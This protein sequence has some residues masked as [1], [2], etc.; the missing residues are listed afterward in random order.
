MSKKNSLRCIS[1]SSLIKKATSKAA[2]LALASLASHG[3]NDNHSPQSLPNLPALLSFFNQY[4]LLFWSLRVSTAPNEGPIEFSFVISAIE[5][6]LVK[7]LN[8]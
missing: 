1:H 6:E 4:P 3:V 7:H 5:L 2:A 8:I